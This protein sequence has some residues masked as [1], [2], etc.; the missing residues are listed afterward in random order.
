VALA[1]AA[2]GFPLAAAGASL[3]SPSAAAY[4]DSTRAGFAGAGASAGAGS[5]VTVG[6]GAAGVAGVTVG[7]VGVGGGSAAGFLVLRAMVVSFH[8][9]R[10]GGLRVQATGLSI[11]RIYRTEQIVNIPE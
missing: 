8:F 2:R 5:S 3:M 1:V 11:V 6:S 7:V 9:P 10:S 4:T